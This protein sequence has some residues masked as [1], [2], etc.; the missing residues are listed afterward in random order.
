MLK[1]QHQ[2]IRHTLYYLMYGVMSLSISML[3]NATEPEQKTVIEEAEFDAAFLIGDAKKI[4][5]DRFKYG[6]PVLSG[7]YSVDVY[8]NGNWFGKHHLLFK[9]PD[10]KSNAFTCFTS[11]ML[12]EYGV[13]PETLISKNTALNPDT[14]QKIEQWVQNAFYD[15]DSSRLRLDISIPQVAMQKNAQ[16]YVDPSLWDHGINAA[17]LSYNAN[18]YKTLNKTQTHQEYTNAFTS[19]SAGINLANWQFRHNGQWQWQDTSSEN[20]SKS[21]YDITSTYLQRAFPQSH[22]VLTLGDRFTNGEIFDSFGYRGVD[23]SSDDRMLP[24]SMSGYA[25]RIRGHAKS[26]AKV[27]VHQQGQLIYQTTVAAGNFEIND[28][29]PTGF[30]GALDVSIVE[31]NGDT[32]RFSIPY[33]SV[34]QML[35]PNMSRYSFTAGQF[36]DKDIALAPWIVQAKYQRGI[37]NYLTSFAGIQASKDYSSVTVGNA[38]AIPIGTVALEMTHSQADFQQREKESGQSFRLSYSKFITPTNTNFTLAASRYST[39]HFYTLH[40]A[41]VAQDLEQTGISPTT[42]GKQRS[43]FQFT[44]NQGLPQHWGS[45]YAMGSWINYWNNPETSRQYQMGYSNHYGALSYNLSAVKRMVGNTTSQ[46]STDDTAYMLTLSLPL[47]IKKNAINFNSTITKDQTSF[48]MNGM[49]GDRFNYGT[50]LSTQFGENPNINMN[51]QYRTNAMTV[52]ASYSMADQYKQA[53]LTARGNIVAHANGVLFGADQ[54]QT[55]VLVYAPDATGA[56]VN[57]ATGLSINQAGYAVVPYVTPYRLNDITL[58]PQEMSSDVELAETSQ[59]IAPYAGAIAQVNFAT[60]TGKAI[61]LHSL[62]TTGKTLP[63]AASAYNAQGENIGM[64]AQG[65]LVYLRTNATADTITIK[66]GENSDEQCHIQ[67][68]VTNQ[69]KNK[70]YNMIMAEAICQ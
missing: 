11:N 66:W 67:Y 10:S 41:L 60:K 48:G 17:F 45:F 27:E 59:R 64:V 1:K 28:L 7:E 69:A 23:F 47:T 36:R 15:F 2:W 19:I 58:D 30:G 6:N 31:A 44:F 34:A 55:M 26:N 63:F 35:R 51:T 39:E 25:P 61:Y 38:I 16:G 40:D 57:N 21:H 62:T 18:A 50:S 54:G 29:Y 24:N 8:V 4:D 33:T 20:Q 22:S 56:K 68:D 43:E 53:M 42:V 37:S 12:L 14:C 32:Q 3:V 13:K 46:Q 52:G 9:A 65:S 49:M 5:I 70:K